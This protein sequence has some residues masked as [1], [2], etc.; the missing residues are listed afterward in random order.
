MI[1]NVF[2][3]KNKK[4]TIKIIKKSYFMV[5]YFNYTKKKEYL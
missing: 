5:S 1:F 3:K 4:K 2:Y